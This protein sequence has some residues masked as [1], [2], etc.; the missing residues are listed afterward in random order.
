M[1]HFK[2]KYGYSPEDTIKITDDELEKAVYAHI[3][4]INGVFKNGTV[5]GKHIIAITEDWHTAM[6]YNDGYKLEADDFAHIKQKLG[7]SY[8]GII[9]LAKQRV[10]DYLAQGKENL[11]GTTPLELPERK[12]ER[13][14]MRSIGEITK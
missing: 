13:G 1:K 11:I 9:A 14:G 5:S 2:I 4:G 12:E 8:T 3:Q 6:G 7:N 10:Q